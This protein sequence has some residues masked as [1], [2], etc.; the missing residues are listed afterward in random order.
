MSY[1]ISNLAQPSRF[2]TVLPR[3]GPLKADAIACAAASYGIP[4]LGERGPRSRILSSHACAHEVARMGT[5][6][7]CSSEG[8]KGLRWTLLSTREG[9][10]RDGLAELLLSDTEITARRAES[11]AGAASAARRD[12]ASGDVS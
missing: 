12:G 3:L 2:L 8:T 5:R 1:S 7:P 4:A 11:R 10:R 9:A 6:R